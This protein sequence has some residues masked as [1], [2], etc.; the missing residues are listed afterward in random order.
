TPLFVCVALAAWAC[1]GPAR[2]EAPDLTATKLRCEYLV[3][4][5]G[6]DVKEP[7]LSWLVESPGRGQKQTAYQVLVAGEE[8]ALKADKGDLWDSGKVASD[9]TTAVVYAGA[10]LGSHQRCYWKVKVWDR[11]GK[12]SGWSEP[13]LWSMGLLAPSDW[14]A[15]WIGY[16]KMRE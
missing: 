15:Q 2:A 8:E 13:A 6:I 16:D 7:R 11:D 12:P 9:E 3:N 10:P 14:K 1:A 4:P 5:L